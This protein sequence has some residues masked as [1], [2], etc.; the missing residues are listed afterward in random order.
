VSPPPLRS[1][2]PALCGANDV[3]RNGHR[4]DTVAPE[5]VADAVF[6]VLARRVADREIEDVQ[7]VL[8]ADIRDLWH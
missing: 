7:Q 1:P 2:G 6:S 3:R 5:R 4:A 8:P